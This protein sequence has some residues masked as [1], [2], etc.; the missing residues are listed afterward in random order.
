MSYPV[1][2]LEEIHQRTLSV[3]GALM[4]DA[5]LS[6][7]GIFWRDDRVTA[8]AVTD[9]HAHLAAVQRDGSPMKA[10]GEALD[11]WGELIGVPRKGAT[12]GRRAQA[13]QVQGTAGTLVGAG[14]V[15][16]HNQTSLRIQITA[17]VAIGADGSTL[18]DVA[19]LDTGSQTNFA[20]GSTFSFLDP[21]DGI[22]QQA[23]L[24]LALKEGD[25][26]EVPGAYRS[27]VIE[28][29]QSPNQ[30]GNRR[31]YEQW[32]REIVGIDSA[33]AL[34]KRA[35]IGTVD[36]VALHRG[37]GNARVLT[38]AE[39][40]EVLG[41]IE[42]RRPLGATIRVLEVVVSVVDVEL[43]VLPLVES[44]YAFDW[45]DDGTGLE[46][47]EYD[48]DNRIV[49]TTAPLPNSFRAGVRLT[50]SHGSEG[51]QVRLA[52]AIVD[53]DSFLLSLDPDEPLPFEPAAGDRIY[54]ASTITEPIRQAI[55][56]GYPAADGT[57][58]PGIN[59][60]GP[61]NFAS[62]YGSWIDDISPSR[63]QA[64]ALAQAGV[65]Q[66]RVSELRQDGTIVET[67][68]PVDPALDVTASPDDTAVIGLLVPGQVLVRRGA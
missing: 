49:T 19:A 26:A 2:T 12:G 53:S 34:D 17:A 55:L 20:A 54:A 60:L 9:N 65:Y 33:Y 24:V 62:R 1:P 64:A 14:T 31:D 57:P 22:N 56:N 50:I 46:I 32:A 27:R 52:Q 66:A 13:L 41:Y 3:R 58:L 67:A 38:E 10:E 11:G 42:E 48:A 35:G 44:Q 61:A 59:Q 30:G 47:A 16:V 25:D 23:R 36:I 39:R 5:D 7:G 18:A 45:D 51:G 37:Q 28:R 6:D 63:V 29:W 40:N 68:T 21:P 4:P 15:L 8:A 43:L